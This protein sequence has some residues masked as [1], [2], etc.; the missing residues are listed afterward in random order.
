[1]SIAWARAFS[2]ERILELNP[3]RLHT[4]EQQHYGDMMHAIIALP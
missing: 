2:L 4:D 1:M 3:G